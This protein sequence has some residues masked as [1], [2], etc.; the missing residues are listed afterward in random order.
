MGWLVGELNDKLIETYNK[1]YITKLI[2]F[3]SMNE[4]FSEYSSVSLE[5]ANLFIEQFKKK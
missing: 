2:Q 1:E 3:L 5:T 4:E